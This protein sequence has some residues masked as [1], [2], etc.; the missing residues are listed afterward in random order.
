LEEKSN[1]NRDDDD[2]E[3]NLSGRLLLS[4]SLPPAPST[5]SSSETGIRFRRNYDVEQQTFQIEKKNIGKNHCFGFNNIHRIRKYFSGSDLSSTEERRAWR[6]VMLLFVSLTAHN[7]P[8]GL[9]VAA[10]TMH[11]KHLG[12]TTTLA[13]ALHNI[14]EGIAISIPCL[15]ARP[16]SP[17]LAFGLAS[18]SGLAEPFGAAVAL[19]FLRDVEHNNNQNIDSHSLLSMTNILAFVAG[20]MIMVAVSE[21][22]PEAARH[23]QNGWGALVAGVVIGAVVMIVTEFYLE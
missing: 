1:D 16:E 10:S 22:L 5:P 8:E 12:L 18:L 23:T 14:P 11:S 6:V 9:A 17:W 20:I 4:H 3:R 13:I 15:A 2:D 21:L 7:F 19:Y